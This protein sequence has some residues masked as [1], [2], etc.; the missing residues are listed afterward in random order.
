M[1]NEGVIVESDQ[2]LD[3]PH[4][5]NKKL[6]NSMDV[7]ALENDLSLIS[8]PNGEVEKPVEKPAEDLIADKTEETPP[9]EESA[10]DVVELTDEETKA[11]IEEIEAK[12]DAD[13]T[14]EEKQFVLDN[15]E[16]EVNAL[17]TIYS[18]LGSPEGL[19]VTKYEDSLEGLANLSRDAGA[20]MAETLAEDKVKQKFDEHP[21]L[22]KL[23]Q[24]SVVEG[25]SLETFLLENQ[26]TEYSELDISN[27]DGQKRLISLYYK[28]EKGLDDNVI[29]SIVDGIENK[30][31]LEATSKKLNDEIKIA[32]DNKIKAINE[33]QQAD[34]RI[35]DEEYK[36][37]VNDVKNTIKKG[38]L[39]TLVLKPAQATEF[40]NQMFSEPVN[41]QTFTD[42]AYNKLNTEQRLLIDYLTINVDKIGS[43]EMFKNSKKVNGKSLSEMYTANKK[44]R[45][46]TKALD[47]TTNGQH[48]NDNID[49]SSIKMEDIHFPSNN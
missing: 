41:G 6:I 25:K 36:T 5:I 28:N 40:E 26:K 31:E 35:A 8:E 12:E 30:G 29:T 44:R 11:K 38:K 3:S 33:Q 14:D 37:L 24:H 43:L 10:D 16:E 32:K 2:S 47:G 13:V 20:I 9:E 49:F 46:V 15:T 45:S 17:D 27:E 21:A 34:K 7:D 42:A 18:E 22:A 48:S 19:D 1:S 39:G 23:Y 4:D